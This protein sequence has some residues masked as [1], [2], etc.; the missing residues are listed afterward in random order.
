MRAAKIASVLTRSVAI[1]LLLHG[2]I[3]L[4]V[5]RCYTSEFSPR[6]HT[7]DSDVSRHSSGSLDWKNSP[8]PEN[9]FGWLAGRNRF[10]GVAGSGA[11]RDS[12]FWR[13]F[14]SKLS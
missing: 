9:D 12:P 2:E 6:S 1:L 13:K 11:L 8:A 3:T 4:S 7:L 14:R 10:E 5:S